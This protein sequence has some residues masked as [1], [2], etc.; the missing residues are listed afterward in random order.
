MKVRELIHYLEK[1]YDPEDALVVAFWDRT[2]FDTADL[3]PEQWEDAAE[4]MEGIDWQYVHKTLG[5][6]LEGYV[7]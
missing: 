7:S 1:Q 6:V 3:T 2:S 4:Y 5:E